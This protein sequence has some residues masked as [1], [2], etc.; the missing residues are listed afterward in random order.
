M[1]R[2]F[3]YRI[4]PSQ[5]QMALVDKHMGA[6][7]FIYNLALETKQMAYSGSK[8]NLSGF[9]LAKQ[10]PDLKKDCPWL[11]EVNSQSLQKAIINMDAAFNNFFKGQADFPKFKSKKSNKQSFCV[12]QNVEIND[13]ELFIPKF[14]QGIPV[15]LHRPIKG[16]IKQA[17]I[18]R[19]PTG[20]YFASILVETGEEIPTNK[21]V[22]EQTTIGIDLGISSFLVDSE[23]NKYANPRHLQKALSRLRF[24]QG[25]LSRFNGKRS[26]HRL[27]KLHE[28][29]ANK[30]HD[31]LHKTSSQLVNSHDSIAIEDLNVSGM[32]QNHAFARAI[33]DSGWATFVSML[34]YKAEWGGKNILRIGRFDPS[35][36]TCS[37]CGAINK[38]LKLSDR[39]WTCRC[40]AHHDRDVN[41]AINI[42]AFALEKNV[43]GTQTQTRSELPTMVG[44][45][46]CEAQ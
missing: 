36:K 31:F 44:V 28:Q 13:G 25:R 32:I 41:A 30:R 43:C 10:I 18:S 19:T 27:A 15:V 11:K 39:E 35:S 23:G 40:G 37:G 16:V 24:V 17:T 34:E 5:E 12:P 2:A 26:R 29:V 22:K 8:I 20:K 9:D 3:K 21:N 46:T 45:L 38:T 14:K 4:Y 1:H 42:K 6:A 7:R 33:A